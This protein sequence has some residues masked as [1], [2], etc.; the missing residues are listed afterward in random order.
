[1]RYR[2]DLSVVSSALHKQGLPTSEG[3][4]RDRKN[5][6]QFKIKEQSEGL[7]KCCAKE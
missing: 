6:L 1:M 5:I 2:T 4:I 3:Q 7:D